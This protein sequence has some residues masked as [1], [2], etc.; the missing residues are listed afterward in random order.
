MDSGS[1]VFRFDDRPP[2]PT[3]PSAETPNGL[4]PQVTSKFQEKYIR[5]AMHSYSI[6]RNPLTPYLRSSLPGHGSM[7]PSGLSTAA[8]RRPRGGVDPRHSP[9]CYVI[10]PSRQPSLIELVQHL[11]DVASVVFRG[12]EWGW[13]KCAEN[14]QTST[15][16]LSLRREV[17]KSV[18]V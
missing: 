13:K 15:L 3:R 1:R 7:W 5:V 4:G 9:I 16:H 6:H 8:T 17:G 11:R 18:T 2:I 14:G 10:P 12:V